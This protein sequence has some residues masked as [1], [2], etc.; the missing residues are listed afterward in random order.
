MAPRAFITGI[1][2]LSLSDDERGFFRESRPW[3]FI[4]FKRNVDNPVQVKALVDDL[5]GTVG[6]PDAPVLIDQEGGRVQRLGPP[7]WPVYPP[8]AVFSTLYDIDPEA[9]LT[10]ARLSARLI[11]D[12]LAALGITVDC[13]PLADVPITG[14]D[15]V[16]GDRAYGTS[17][18]KVAAI[19][20]AVTDGLAQGGV[21][22][23]LKH[24]PGHGR[25]TADSHHLL[26]TVE[27][28]REELDRTDFAAFRPL[29]DLPMAMTA[30]VVFSALDAA[31]PA[32][33]S[34]TIIDRVI[35]DSI[36]FQGLLMSDDV[37][38][39]A[40]AGSIAERTRAIVAAGCDVVLHC[41]GKL[42]EMRQVVAETPE[43]QGRALT[44]A[45]AALAARHAP[46]PFDRAAARAELDA[47]IGRAR[48][49]A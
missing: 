29:A 18:D 26:P 47:L 31:Q 28:S 5:R 2:G 25:A 48:V 15:A 45:E 39:N 4:L 11:A 21:L 14:A 43:L 44:R 12:D 23:V 24:I 17:P 1:A 46:Q 38:M 41:N 19:A 10:A 33:T 27:T 13:L 3:G 49:G 16:I 7:H 8:G 22:P 20:R 34:A 36:G 32:T 42:D 9:G 35:R 6:S 30:H 37:S 40:L